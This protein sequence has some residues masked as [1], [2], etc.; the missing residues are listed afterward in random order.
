M[1]IITQLWHFHSTVAEGLCLHFQLFCP[2][3]SPTCKEN[4]TLY[5]LDYGHVV[6]QRS[7]STFTTLQLMTTKKES[8]HSLDVSSL[9]LRTDNE[10][11]IT[12]HLQT[13]CSFLIA[14][15]PP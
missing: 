11:I 6:L 13:L 8:D 12:E 14:L 10:E 4:E 15:L 1:F 9:K 3:T 5:G 2:N 7:T